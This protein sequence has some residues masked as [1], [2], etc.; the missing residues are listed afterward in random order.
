[1]GEGIPLDE[2]KD[3]RERR[4]ALLWAHLPEP[5]QGAH[6]VNNTLRV[7]RSIRHAAHTVNQSKPADARKPEVREALRGQHPT[8]DSSRL[9]EAEKVPLS[10]AATR[11][12]QRHHCAQQGLDCGPGPVDI[13][14]DLCCVPVF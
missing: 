7:K 1:M 10:G 2:A 11:C 8:A 6:H 3:E 12:G 14:D 5:Q 13:S 4:A 9:L